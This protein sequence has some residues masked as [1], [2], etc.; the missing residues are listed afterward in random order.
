VDFS[1]LWYGWKQDGSVA[2][3]EAMLRKVEEKIGSTE[4]G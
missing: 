4:A 3:E 1:K 2:Q